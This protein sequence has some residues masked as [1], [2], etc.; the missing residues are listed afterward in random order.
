[1]NAGTILIAEDDRVLRRA[2]DA[3]L[4]ARG[5]TTLLAENGTQA[6]ALARVQT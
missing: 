4:R 3:T 1:M 6:L 2:C 5:Y